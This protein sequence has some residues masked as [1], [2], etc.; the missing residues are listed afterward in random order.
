MTDRFFF[1]IGSITVH[2]QRQCGDG[3]RQDSDA[4][5]DGCGLQ[6][7]LLVDSLATGACAEEKAVSVAPEAILR[8]NIPKL[9]IN[10][11]LSRCYNGY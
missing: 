4:G 10:Y 1:A 6:R 5:V 3:F 2:V 9:A 8:Q 7:C 11:N